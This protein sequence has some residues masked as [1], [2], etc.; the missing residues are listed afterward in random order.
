MTRACLRS[1]MAHSNS[2]SVGGGLVRVMV[3][4]ENGMAAAFLDLTFREFGRAR[5]FHGCRAATED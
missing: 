1:P 2:D 5:Q 4:A 3:L